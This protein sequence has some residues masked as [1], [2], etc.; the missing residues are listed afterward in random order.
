MKYPRKRLAR[1]IMRG[2]GRAVLRIFFRVQIAGKENF[3][4]SG[5]I[6]L[7]GNHTALM[8][9]VLFHTLTPWQVEMLGSADIPHET[10]VGIITQIF[11]F[12]PVRRGHMERASMQMALD[13]LKQNGVIGIFPEGG[14][15]DTGRMQ[16]QTGVAWLS[17]RAGA[18]VLPMGFSSSLGAIG[19]ALRL[20]R[21]RLTMTVGKLLPAAK[22][23]E[24][25]AKKVFLQEYANQVLDAVR[26]L[27][28]KDDP[29]LKV[30]ILN[31]RFEMEIAVHDQGGEPVEIPVELDIQHPVELAKVLHRP[32]IL[33]I[34]D[35]NLHMPVGPIQ[36]LHTRPAPQL[37]VDAIAPILNYL[38]SE[39]PYLFAYRFGPKQGEAMKYGLEEMNRLAQWA[40]END[41]SLG[42][43]P[44]RRFTRPGQAGEI[45]Q[46]KQGEFKNWM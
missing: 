5:P 9:T 24:G 45:V 18:P 4:K 22:I 42:I 8:E 46:T 34:F 40:V 35:K 23:P 17:Y 1:G 11:G 14:I 43:T 20:R 27:I 12:I 37:I 36:N 21:P 7:V 15:W 28:P 16:A 38:E 39:N 2:L 10:F 6:I 3:P 44:I 31:E 19:A 30:N 32:A 41:Y 13:V 25:K 26:A 29:S 33:K